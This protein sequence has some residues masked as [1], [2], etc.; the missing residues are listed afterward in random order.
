MSSS[1]GTCCVVLTARGVPDLEVASVA[2]YP[3]LA[4]VK[5]DDGDFSTITADNDVDLRSGNAAA[6]RCKLSQSSGVKRRRGGKA[7]NEATTHDAL[8]YPEWS[9]IVYMLWHI[10]PLICFTACHV[11][12]PYR[13][14]MRL[15]DGRVGGSR[16]DGCR[17]APCCPGP[18]RQRWHSALDKEPPKR[19]VGRPRWEDEGVSRRKLGPEAHLRV[20]VGVV[21]RDLYHR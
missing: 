8:P 16:R 18:I 14:N 3:K 10:Q 5:G 2:A 4:S 12:R 9:N 11:Y 21:Y 19:L 6:K 15:Q 1:E 17:G 13:T 20:A 7:E